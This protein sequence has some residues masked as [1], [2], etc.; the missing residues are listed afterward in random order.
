MSDYFP[1][2]VQVVP[3]KDYTVS[4][5]FSDGKIVLYNVNPLLE[6]G[7]FTQLKDIHIFMN[8]CMILN[9]TLAWDIAGNR[10][11]SRCIDI[12]PDQLYSLPTVNEQ[13]A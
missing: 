2:I 10:D 11:E 13:T 9:D 12:D 1:E 4:V 8:S 5:Y 3:H 7:L 6:K